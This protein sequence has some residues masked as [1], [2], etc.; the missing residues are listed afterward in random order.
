M[1]RLQSPDRLSVGALDYSYCGTHMSFHDESVFTAVLSERRTGSEPFSFAAQSVV[2]ILPTEN[3]SRSKHLAARAASP[4]TSV[5]VGLFFPLVSPLDSVVFAEQFQSCRW[6]SG[7]INLGIHIL[8]LV[9]FVVVARA[10][11]QLDQIVV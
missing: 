6:I 7:L 9:S 1:S 11:C 5:S 3:S 10:I 8:K 2:Q 4:L